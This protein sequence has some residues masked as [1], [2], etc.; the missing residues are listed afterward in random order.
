MSWYAG[1]MRRLGHTTFFAR[2]GSRVAPPLDRFLH[3]VSGGRLHVAESFLPT[4][5][6][7]T[8]GRRSGQARQQ[9]LAYV[10]VDGTL[11]VVGTNWGGENHPAWTYN[12][13]ADPEARVE[14]R[15]TSTRVETRLVDEDDEF[16]RAWARFVDIWPAYETYLERTDRD[17]RMFAL[18]P[19]PAGDR[20][21]TSGGTP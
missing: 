7:T 12:L 1:L 3:R 18:E 2:F 13:L 19:A 8:T 17:P 9:P 11:Y 15:G 16:A 21:G 4:L 14:R 20:G 6:L 10:E 5:I